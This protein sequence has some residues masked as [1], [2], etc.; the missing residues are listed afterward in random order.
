MMQT[1][2]RAAFGGHLCGAC[3]AAGLLASVLGV[4]DSGA[5]VDADAGATDAGADASA[6][7]PYD[8]AEVVVSSR[9]G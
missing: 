1:E 4:G 9:R 2:P 5:A 8:L 6:R 7:A 3:R